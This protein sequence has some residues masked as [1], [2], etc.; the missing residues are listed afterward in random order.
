MNYPLY[1]IKA[2]NMKTIRKQAYAKR[3]NPK[4]HLSQMFALRFLDELKYSR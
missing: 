4:D 2:F 3:R 1:K